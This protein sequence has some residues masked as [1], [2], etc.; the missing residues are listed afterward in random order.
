[1][2][3][4]AVGVR[5]DASS[6]FSDGVIGYRQDQNVGVVGGREEIIATAEKAQELI[7][8]SATGGGHG[9]SG[10]ALTYESQSLSGDLHGGFPPW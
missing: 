3:D 8:D 7:T 9:R 2:Q 5:C 10:L 4:E 6:N 1:V